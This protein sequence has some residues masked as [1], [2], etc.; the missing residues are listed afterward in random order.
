VAVH[1]AAMFAQLGNVLCVCPQCEELFYLPEARPYLNGK[2]PRSIV[3][4]LRAEEQ[5]LDRAEERLDELEYGLREK[6][7]EAGLRAAKKSLKKIDPLFS[8]SGYNPHDVKV[9]FDPIT[10]VVFN[11]IGAGRLREIVLL[12]DPAQS[13]AEERLQNSIEGAVK[14]GNFEFRTL[15]VDRDGK[16]AER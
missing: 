3:D 16:V 13:V 10:Y 15:H 5:K 12:T 8:G 6:A 14:R 1:I 4:A 9:I 7:A 2:Q 11:G